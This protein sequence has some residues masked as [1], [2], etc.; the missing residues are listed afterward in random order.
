MSAKTGLR[1]RIVDLLESGEC[2]DVH[3]DISP[4]FNVEKAADAIA[5]LFPDIAALSLTL[6]KQELTQKLADAERE[7]DATRAELMRVRTLALDAERVNARSAT[8]LR[9]A[10]AV[11]RA[12]D[13]AVKAGWLHTRTTIT[14]AREDYSAPYTY[15]TPHPPERGATV[16]ESWTKCDC[17]M[18][19]LVDQRCPS[20]GATPPEQQSRNVRRA[21]EASDG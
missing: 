14:D 12:I 9:A 8:N 20:C 6:D 1:E 3:D 16:P 7:R 11:M 2:W 18:R 4:D 10:D 13:E 21:T 5:S 15:L 19:R 17:G